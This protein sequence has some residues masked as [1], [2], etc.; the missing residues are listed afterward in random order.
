[1]RKSCASL[2]YSYLLNIPLLRARPSEKSEE[3]LGDRLGWKCTVHPECR[4]ASDQFIIACL[5]AFIGIANF[6]TLVKFMD[7]ENSGICWRELLDHSLALIGSTD[8]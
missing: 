4:H 6:N 3:G 7:T 1:V 5:C 8:G 2:V